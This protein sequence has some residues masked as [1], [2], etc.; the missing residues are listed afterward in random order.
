MGRRGLILGDLPMK[1]IF[2]EAFIKKIPFMRKDI[3]LLII[4]NH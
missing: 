4:L 1:I 2:D 3:F